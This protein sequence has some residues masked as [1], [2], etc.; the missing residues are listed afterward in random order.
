[1]GHAD[2]QEY[3]FGSKLFDHL[4]RFRCRARC[5]YNLKVRTMPFNLTTQRL[6]RWH[7]IVYNKTPDG[8]I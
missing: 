4:K 6:A 7:F 3:H 1:M 5:L 2:I 8:L